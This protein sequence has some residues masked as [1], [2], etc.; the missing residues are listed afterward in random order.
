MHL[1]QSVNTS[2]DC[3]G[4]SVRLGWPKVWSPQCKAAEGARW[5][6]VVHAVVVFEPLGGCGVWFSLWPAL[7]LTT[8][9]G[10]ILEVVRQQQAAIVYLW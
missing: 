5:T 10:S 6:L 2:V 8:D 7:H 1:Y 9:Q 4:L 3:A